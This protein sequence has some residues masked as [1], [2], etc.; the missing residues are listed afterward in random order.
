MPRFFAQ[1]T[2]NDKIKIK[3][4]RHSSQ[5]CKKTSQKAKLGTLRLLTYKP[6][7]LIMAGA[8]KII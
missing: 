8:Y 3:V 6:I 2:V 7:H 5:N 1:S 4:I